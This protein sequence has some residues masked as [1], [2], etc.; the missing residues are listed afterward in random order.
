M[1]LAQS[2]RIDRVTCSISRMHVSKTTAGHR[3]GRNVYDLY[4]NDTGRSFA[5]VAT[6]RPCLRAS[7]ARNASIRRSERG[8]PRNQRSGCGTVRNM[9]EK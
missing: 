1:K 6:Q 7:I 4:Q 5:K 2:L 8:K 9:N 3:L